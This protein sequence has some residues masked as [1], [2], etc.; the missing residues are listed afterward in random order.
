MAKG[1][2]FKAAVVAVE[3]GM[4]IK[5]INRVTNFKEII[6]SKATTMV[7]TTDHT[8]AI[9]RENP[10]DK[11]KDNGGTNILPR[12]ETETCKGTISIKI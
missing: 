9:I 6:S 1:A 5:E 4:E 10:G 11:V 8:R 7:T 12:D 2:D 3:G